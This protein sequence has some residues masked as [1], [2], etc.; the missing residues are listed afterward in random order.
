MS[1]DTELD[2]DQY[3]ALDSILG[4]FPFGDR[5]VEELIARIAGAD[6]GVN[7]EDVE[8]ILNPFVVG[9]LDVGSRSSATSRGRLPALQSD[10]RGARQ[11]R[12]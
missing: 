8:P 10:D 2:G 1:I 6:S 12:R 7:F 9:A 5:T 11:P 4:K 3:K